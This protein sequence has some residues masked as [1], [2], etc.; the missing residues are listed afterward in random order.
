MEPIVIVGGGIVGTGLAYFLRDAPCEVRLLEKNTLGSG[1]TAASIAMFSWLQTEPTEL[2]HELRTRSWNL[3]EPMIE[4]G[5]I[6]F[7]RTGA[8]DCA[9]SEEGLRELETAV[10]ILQEFGL[11]VELRTPEQLAEF[12]I[13]TQQ[14]H[15]GMYLHREGYLD[16]TEII[17]TWADRAVEAGV[18]IE[19]GVEVHDI[20][21]EDGEVTGV[22][23][24][25][26][27]Y[28]AGTV[29]NAAGPWAPSIAEMVDISLPIRHTHGRILVLQPETPVSL[30]FVLFEDGSYFRTEGRHQVFAGKLKREYASAKRLD[31]NAKYGIDEA[32]RKT[33]ARSTGRYV[34]AL[35]DADIANEWVGLRAVTPDG[36]PILGPTD[37]D[38]FLQA[39]GMSGLGVTIAPAVT[40]DL[41][42]YALTGSNDV[43]E[44]L[45]VSRFE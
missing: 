11:E 17:R 21:T 13:D 24:E 36:N 23:T 44:R 45:S 25:T 32:F 9:E 35:M 5:E 6:S 38:G 33:V 14:L 42:E 20:H 28:D 2:E 16:P 26:G 7:E 31:P 18:D 4:R 12:D 8:L 41:A 27:A 34:P 37:V 19:T 10:S 40:S 29:I 22:E 43:V 15:G 39:T 30:P 3:Y 1:A